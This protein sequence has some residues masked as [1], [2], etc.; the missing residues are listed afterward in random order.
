MIDAGHLSGPRLVFFLNAVLSG[1]CSAVSLLGL[2]PFAGLLDAWVYVRKPY[3]WSDHVTMA[4]WHAG[5]AGLFAANLFACLRFGDDPSRDAAE[6]AYALNAV[7]HLYWGV[8]NFV[9]PVR[10]FRCGR[11]T[12]SELR[13]RGLPFVFFSAVGACGT[14]VV[15]NG[16]ALV[17]GPN[18]R[19]STATWIYEWLSLGIVVSDLLYHLAVEHTWGM[20]KR[21]GIKAKS[22]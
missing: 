14:A 7:M 9:V 10:D 5:C 13:R 16:Y 6:L 18:D 1:C 4:W 22:S 15:R 20:A 19:V 12:E 2:W 3:R 8:A 17:R 11:G 21:R